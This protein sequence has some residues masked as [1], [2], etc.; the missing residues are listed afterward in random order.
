[1][2]SPR[3]AGGLRPPLALLTGTPHFTYKH[4]PSAY[5]STTHTH[6]HTSTGKSVRT[7]T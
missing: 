5:A 6:T 7:H 4:I 1:M 3:A 2:V